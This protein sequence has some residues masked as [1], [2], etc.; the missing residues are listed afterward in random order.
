MK[1]YVNA[2]ES[3][4]NLIKEVILDSVAEWGEGGIDVTL[5]K[6]DRGVKVL[7]D[8]KNV[9]L[10]YSD[11]TSLLK[12]IGIIISKGETKYETEQNL[13][14]RQLGNMVDVSRNAVMNIAT[15]KKFIRMSALMDF[16][17]LNLY[18]EDTYEIEG[19]PYF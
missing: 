9:T 15:V 4:Q 3:L 11:L 2:N 12:G 18:T 17:A 8:G 1:I 13:K 16:N 14:Y 19:E 6:C 10:Y 7:S 5:D